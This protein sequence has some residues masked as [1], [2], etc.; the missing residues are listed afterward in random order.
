MDRSRLTNLDSLR[1][2]MTLKNAPKPGSIPQMNPADSGTGRL[3][4]ARRHGLA[5]DLWRGTNLLALDKNFKIT[6]EKTNS[7][8]ILVV[9]NLL[10]Y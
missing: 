9:G 6:V 1:V 3:C 8:R 10:E 7:K 2:P 5:G 4:D